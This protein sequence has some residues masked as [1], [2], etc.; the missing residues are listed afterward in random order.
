MTRPAP[1]QL[2]LFTGPA[3]APQWRRQ[4]NPLFESKDKLPLAAASEPQ[5]GKQLYHLTMTGIY[6]GRPL[7]GCEK[8]AAKARGELF[9]HAA[10][11]DGVKRADTCVECLQ[12]WDDAATATEDD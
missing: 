2:P 11:S 12:M 7:C 1:N 4:G 9:V 6:A 5:G 3:P 10:Y 8:A